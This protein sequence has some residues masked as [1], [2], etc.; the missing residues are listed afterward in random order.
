MRKENKVVAEASNKSV[1]D[2][3]HLIASIKDLYQGIKERSHIP[4][5]P[6]A[7]EYAIRAITEQITSDCVPLKNIKLKR[8]D[9]SICIMENHTLHQ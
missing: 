8:R 5:S 3:Y 6:L 1:K 7:P 4:S 9:Y 2:K